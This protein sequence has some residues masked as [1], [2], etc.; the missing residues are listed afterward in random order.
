MVNVTKQYST[1][2]SQAAGAV[3]KAADIWTRGMREITDR[4]YRTLKLPQ[5]DLVP[6]VERYFDLVQRTVDVNRGL[7]VRWARAAT[8]LSG[9]VRERAESAGD[10]V[11]ERADSL[12]GL[13][14]AKA[15]AI[16]RA[17]REQALKAATVS[18]E[19]AEQAERADQE[20][21]QQARKLQRE[22]SRQAHQRARERYEGMTKAELSDLLAR[23]ELPKT[24]NADELV[25]RLIESDNR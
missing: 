12:G 24:G 18:R 4:T 7:S 9:T 17:A 11:R 1:A 20:R 22:R 2:A 10:V 15:D 16:E 19:Q 8:T 5:V 21:A 13:V 6:A 25:E 3:E 14:R 23:R